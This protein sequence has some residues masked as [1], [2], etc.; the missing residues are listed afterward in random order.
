MC[1]MD[2]R[3]VEIFWPFGPQKVKIMF[4]FWVLHIESFTAGLWFFLC[5]TVLCP[6]YSSKYEACGRE[7]RS[8]DVLAQVLGSVPRMHM[9]AQLYL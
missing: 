5:I 4:M 1:A 6:G 7:L 8:L 2:D 9:M 3:E